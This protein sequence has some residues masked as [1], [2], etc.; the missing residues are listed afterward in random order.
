MHLEETS[1][2]LPKILQITL[3]IFLMKQ[4]MMRLK[5]ETKIEPTINE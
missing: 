3:S 4:L 2:R 1:K 5:G